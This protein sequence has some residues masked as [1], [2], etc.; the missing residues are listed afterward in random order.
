MERLRIRCRISMRRLGWLDRVVRGRRRRRVRRGV[1]RRGELRD[2]HRC[3]RRL[4]E[5]CIDHIGDKRRLSKH[6]TPSQTL[7]Q[8]QSCYHRKYLLALLSQRMRS[9][10][11]TLLVAI[12]TLL[13]LKSLKVRIPN[14]VSIPAKSGTLGCVSIKAARSSTATIYVNQLVQPTVAG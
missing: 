4:G 2:E 3:G 10:P 1:L 14:S 7:N 13:A 9:A 12:R 5:V 11:R 8:V 6:H